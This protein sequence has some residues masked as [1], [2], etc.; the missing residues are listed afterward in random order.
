MRRDKDHV[1]ERNLV[2]DVSLGS[3]GTR[4]GE[5]GELGG[6]MYRALSSILSAP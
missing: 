2:S 5:I 3:R 4:E 1:Y 6:S